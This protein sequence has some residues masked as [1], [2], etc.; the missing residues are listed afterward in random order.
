M[1]GLQQYKINQQR[2]NQY[3][4]EVDLL[5]NGNKCDNYKVSAVASHRPTEI[6]PISQEFYAKTPTVFCIGDLNSYSHRLSRWL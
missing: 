1:Y 2:Q 6:I 3:V 5:P 4:I